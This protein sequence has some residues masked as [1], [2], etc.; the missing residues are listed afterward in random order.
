M[1]IMQRNEQRP[2]PLIDGVAGIRQAQM[3]RGA[4][5][6]PQAEIAFQPLHCSTEAR[7][8]MPEHA[9]GGAKAAMLHDFAKQLPIAPVH[10]QSSMWRDSVSRE[11]GYPGQRRSP[12]TWHKLSAFRK[13]DREESDVR[14]R[15]LSSQFLVR[16][17]LE[18]RIDRRQEARPHHPG[19]ARG[20]LSRRQRQ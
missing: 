2:D 12:R 14:R 13:T 4:F 6:Q 5:D 17:S 16:R 7:F 18:S 11:S 9:R 20:D 3:T 1:R 10:P 19:K 15:N 8:G